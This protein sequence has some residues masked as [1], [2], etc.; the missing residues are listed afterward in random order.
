[1]KEVEDPE[2]F[3]VAE[4]A[5]D[6]VVGIEEKPANPKTKY[7]VTGIYMYDS[8][9]FEIIETLEPSNRGELEITDVNNEYIRRGEMAYDVLDGWWTDA[10][11]FESLHKA[12]NL[13]ASQK[14]DPDV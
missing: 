14:V 1:L 12:S 8:R 13:V 10:G 5:D 2:R 4:L 3:G 11:T 9:V 7:A 6:R